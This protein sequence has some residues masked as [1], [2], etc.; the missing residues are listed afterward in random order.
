[1]G[2]APRAARGE[3]KAHAATAN[4][5]RHAAYLDG[6]GGG[7]V[8]P[9][10]TVGKGIAAEDGMNDTAGPQ[11]L[12]G[13]LRGDFETIRADDGTDMFVSAAVV[14]S[15]FAE[16]QFEAVQ[17]FVVGAHEDVSQVGLDQALDQRRG[18]HVLADVDEDVVELVAKVAEQWRHLS[19]FAGIG[20][21]LDVQFETAR[22][23][24][25][26]FLGK[27][28]NP[29]ERSFDPGPGG[30]RNRSGG[31]AEMNAEHADARDLGEDA[32]EAVSH[33]ALIDAGG[34]GVESDDALAGRGDARLD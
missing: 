26:H 15:Q 1:M 25:P 28:E 4:F 6:E 19:G 24:L 2:E 22:T 16:E 32:G 13:E 14:R 5:P 8:N 3:G 29:V 7:S 27:P 20:A 30:E 31:R 17:A 10:M 33:D 18:R 23:N 9:S 11:T 21:G 34:E 12:V